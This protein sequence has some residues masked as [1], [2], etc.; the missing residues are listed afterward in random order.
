MCTCIHLYIYSRMYACVCLFPLFS[1]HA[2]P[3]FP[4]SP[5]FVVP[6]C[7]SPCASL[8]LSLSLFPLSFS[9][10]CSWCRSLFLSFSP[11]LSLALFFALP[12][13]LFCRAVGADAERV[14]LVRTGLAKQVFHSPYTEHQDSQASLAR[15]LLQPTSGKLASMHAACQGPFCP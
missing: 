14:C 13:L 5:F 11:S 8:L 9:F 2:C 3:L 1:D 15:V 6:H 12:L 4:V 10:S 7:L